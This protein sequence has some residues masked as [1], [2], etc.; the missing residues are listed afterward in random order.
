M[1]VLNKVLLYVRA[2]EDSRHVR[3]V[4]CYTHEEDIPVDLQFFVETMVIACS[5]V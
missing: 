1:Q 4:H 3:M 5:G 2:N